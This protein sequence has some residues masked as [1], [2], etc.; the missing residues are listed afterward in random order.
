MTTATTIDARTARFTVA[1][2]DANAIVYAVA[3]AAS[4][5]GE[6]LTFA[7]ADSPGD[8]HSIAG[9]CTRLSALAAVADQ[10]QWRTHHGAHGQPTDRLPV[11]TDV[12]TVLDLAA[13]LDRHALDAERYGGEDCPIDSGS[14]APARATLAA[15]IAEHG[16]VTT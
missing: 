3:S 5:I 11:A 6:E 14:F 12:A 8:L 1:P 4:Q 13:L 7:P 2:A 10:L 15:V 16:T 9:K